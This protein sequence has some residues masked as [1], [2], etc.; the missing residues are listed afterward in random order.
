MSTPKSW[1]RVDSLQAYLQPGL[2]R[3]W[4]ELKDWAETL[5]ANT[6]K[7]VIA[8]ELWCF[9]SMPFSLRLCGS[10]QVWQKED[11]TAEGYFPI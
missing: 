11:L 4:V 2:G 5:A 7:S 6:E 9:K 10:S 8:C 1:C 3:D